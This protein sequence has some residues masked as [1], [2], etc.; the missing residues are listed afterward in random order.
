MYRRYITDFFMDFYRRISSLSVV[1]NRYFVAISIFF[2][3]SSK[4]RRFFRYF[5]NSCFNQLSVSNIVSVA[6]I[7]DI[8]V[9]IF[10]IFVH[11]YD[12]DDNMMSILG[13]SPLIGYVR[14]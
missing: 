8:S 13:F 3:I 7:S 2:D 9:D 14:F 11:G 10:D 5:F 6:T 4:Y 12:K 1:D